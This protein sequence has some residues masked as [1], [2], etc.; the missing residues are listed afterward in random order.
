MTGGTRATSDL[1]GLRLLPAERSR[2][3]T[4]RTS[5]LVVA[6]S[7]LVP[8]FAHACDVEAADRQLK[9][10]E[11]DIAGGNPERGAAAASSALKLDPACTEALFVRG[12][13]L[14]RSGRESEASALLLTY[15][16]LRGTLALDP[17]FELTFGLVEAAM[18]PFDAARG[19]R[20]ADMALTQLD[21]DV[22]A[23]Q[24]AAVEA[25]EPRGE[26]HARMLGLQA[27]LLWGRGDRDAAERTWRRLFADHPGAA[28]DSELPPEQIAAMARAQEAVSAGTTTRTALRADPTA[29]WVVLGSTG[30]GLAVAGVVVAGVEHSRGAG[31]LDSMTGTGGYIDNV[32]AYDGARRGEQF[33]VV[34]SGVGTA[35]LVGGVV[36]A[37]VQRA[38]S[39]RLQN[40]QEAKR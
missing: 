37:L 31:L 20:L 10:A 1:E 17:R 36:A 38:E 26:V 30:A 40:R 16:D 32:D 22:A 6:L 8:G 7:L 23:D 21:L 24:L 33:G 13:A 14:H 27:Q 19:L 28:V 11:A 34:L 35:A 18:Q 15:R 2:V 9:L 4:L 3:G 12:L 29:P 5:A 25:A 39:K